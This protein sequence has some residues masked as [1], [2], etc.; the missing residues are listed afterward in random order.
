MNA[1]VWCGMDEAKADGEKDEA[2]ALIYDGQC[3][4]C[5]AYSGAVSVDPKD[6]GSIDRIDARS[7]HP[8]V[9]AARAAGLDLDDGMVVV[10]QG[11]LHH[12]ADALH[13]MATLAPRK[14]I[15]NRL[16]RLFFGNRT[17]SRVAY[18]F[19]RAG[20][21]ALLKILGRKKIG[22]GVTS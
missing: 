6:A 2:V 11:A 16:N 18:P 21:N 4:V 22:A 5:T 20:R 17:I 8:L 15:R 1:K 3:P 9:A 14:G 12:G 7:N 19:L 13:L 10:Y